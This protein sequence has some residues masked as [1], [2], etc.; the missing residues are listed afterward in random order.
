[1]RQESCDAEQQGPYGSNSKV[2]AICE[3]LGLRYCRCGW[4]GRCEERVDVHV[5]SPVCH[6][7][8]RQDSSYRYGGCSR[9]GAP[10]DGDGSDSKDDEKEECDGIV[11]ARQYQERR[12]EQIDRKRK[13]RKRIDLLVRS[14]GAVEKIADQERGGECEACDG[15]EQVRAER[16]HRVYMKIDSGQRPQRAEYK[17]CERDRTPQPE[18]RQCEGRR[19]DHGEI[20]IQRPEIRRGGRNQHR[21]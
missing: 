18:S 21:R 9:R 4:T 14:R 11:P 6:Y 17:R 2:R 19:V 1:L 7:C 8:H 20:D 3:P 10:R 15:V 13:R 5:H 12:G 16:R